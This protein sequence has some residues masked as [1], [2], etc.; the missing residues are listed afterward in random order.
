MAGFDSFQIAQGVAAAG[1]DINELYM[2]KL[3]EPVVA[4]FGWLLGAG[5]I[6]VLALCF[7][8]NRAR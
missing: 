1:G 6:M 2:G 7:S 5:I 4:H 8:K 3:S